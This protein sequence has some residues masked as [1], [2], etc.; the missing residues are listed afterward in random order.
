M[1]TR[2]RNRLLINAAAL[3]TYREISDA[4]L[5]DLV[6]AYQSGADA[7]MAKAEYERSL[8]PVWRLEGQIEAIMDGQVSL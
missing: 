2:T 5:F 4:R 3:R 7:V 1:N 6:S 8:L